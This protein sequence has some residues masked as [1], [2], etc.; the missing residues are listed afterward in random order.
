MRV[1]V[2]VTPTARA[3]LL[4]LLESRTRRADDALRTAGVYLDD[5]EQQFQRHGGA[6]PDAHVVRRHGEFWW[7]YLDGVWL[8]YLVQDRARLFTTIR[9]I[10]LIAVEAHPT[11]EPPPRA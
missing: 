2:E 5:L 7:L 10:K 11:G 3:E 8:G 9:R 1:E 4:R 6:P